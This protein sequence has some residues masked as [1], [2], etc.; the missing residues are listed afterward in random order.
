MYSIAKSMGFRTYGVVS[1]KALKNV[2]LAPKCETVV[3]IQDT[4]WGGFLPDA[5]DTLS[6]TSEVLV[7]TSDRMI[8]VG[9]GVVGVAEF[10]VAISRGLSVRV[11]NVEASKPNTRGLPGIASEFSG[12]ANALALAP[13]NT[14]FKATV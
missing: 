6:P 8:A 11:H 13:E 1:S 12:L 14:W 9:G 2:R 3:F 7:G 4:T 5:L 10:T